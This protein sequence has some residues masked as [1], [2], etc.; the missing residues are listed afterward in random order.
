MRKKKKRKVKNKNP[1]KY[2]TSPFSTTISGGGWLMV[3]LV[4]VVVTDG[5]NWPSLIFFK[6]VTVAF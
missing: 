4:G 3:V 1:E 6:S 2:K 5:G